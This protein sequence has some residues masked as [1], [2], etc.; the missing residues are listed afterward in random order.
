MATIAAN[1]RDQ[2]Q[3]MLILLLQ[4][5]LYMRLL[6]SRNHACQQARQPE[7]ESAMVRAV[8]PHISQGGHVVEKLSFR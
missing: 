4:E 2:R 5:R 1:L 3:I 7:R 8:H 6:F